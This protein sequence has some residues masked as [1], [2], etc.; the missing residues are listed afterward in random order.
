MSAVDDQLLLSENR[1]TRA[2]EAL[3]DERMGTH[4]MVEA[5]LAQR[6]AIHALTL[7]IVEMSKPSHVEIHVDNGVT[8]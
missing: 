7:A 5:A 1:A 6:D 4:A 8:Q 3:Y 2:A